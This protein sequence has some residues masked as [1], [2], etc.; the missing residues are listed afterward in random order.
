MS[1]QE[2]LTKSSAKRMGRGYIASIAMRMFEDRLTLFVAIL[3]GAIVVLVT[4][5]PLFATYDPYAGSV[6]KR[7]APVATEGHFLGTDEGG[8]DLWSR[9]LYGGRLSLLVG[10]LP[11]A[12]ALAVGGT[13]GMLAGYFRGIINTAI[14]RTTDVC[15]AFPSIL[16]AI[17]IAGVLG[18]G[19][20]N[21]VIALSV[22]F[23][24]PIVRISE[25]VT[26]QIRHYDYVE[27]AR[28]SGASALT[29]L[30]RQILIN[31]IG[32]LI[33][34]ATSLTSISVILA[35]GMSFLGLGISPPEAE[36]GS[37]LNGMRQ[38]IW[39]QPLNAA[40]PGAMI[41]V[42]SMCF[43]LLSDGLRRAMSVRA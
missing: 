7:L 43:N 35:A 32:P 37:M 2:P 4:F 15:Y 8:R 18:S 39:V 1:A 25:S 29:V 16:L 33:V 42:T 34:Y 14:M 20:R 27:A 31:A 17:A 28:A 30:R 36:W 24:P 6:L 38:A 3:L 21:A 22:S 12:I 9:I 26:A 41:F 11:V 23:V 40:I 10:T 13:L 5:A 19:F